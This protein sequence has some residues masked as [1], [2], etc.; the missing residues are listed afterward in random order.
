MQLLVELAITITA[1]NKLN[2]DARKMVDKWG[3]IGRKAKICR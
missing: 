2:F 1:F 3:G